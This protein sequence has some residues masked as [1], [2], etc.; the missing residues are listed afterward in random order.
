MTLTTASPGQIVMIE[1]NIAVGTLRERLLALGFIREAKVHVL[2]RGH[3]NQ[4]TVFYLGG[5]MLALRKEESDLILVR[6]I[7][8]D[9]A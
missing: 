6:T 2:Y 1:Q 4:L 9:E 3:H 8:G 5:V 7:K